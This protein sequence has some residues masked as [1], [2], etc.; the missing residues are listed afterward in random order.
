MLCYE[1]FNYVVDAPS[2]EILLAQIYNESQDVD[3]GDLALV[4]MLLSIGEF[5][6][7][8][9]HWPLFLMSR[10]ILYTSIDAAVATAHHRILQCLV[11]LTFHVRPLALTRTLVPTGF[12]PILAIRGGERLEAVT[13]DSRLVT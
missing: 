5:L 13:R 8:Y 12:V 2:V 1:R 9:W 6:K 7:G 3:S 4:L 11:I 10:T